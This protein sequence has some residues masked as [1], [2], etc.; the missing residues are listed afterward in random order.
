MSV[1]VTELQALV[2][3]LEKA[4]ALA[5]T[6]MLPIVKRGAQNIKD[7]AR[8]LAPAG[9]KTAHYPYSLGYDLT[10]TG[11]LTEAVIG[12]DLSMPQGGLGG[13]LEDGT[14]RSA[15]HPHLGPA[16]EHEAPRF[17]EEISK[18]AAGLL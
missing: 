10:C 9:P 17:V 15:P 2:G 14:S 7:E 3:D 4:G 6:T 1:D 8:L 18:A 11:T 5:A 12:A 13:I 16:L